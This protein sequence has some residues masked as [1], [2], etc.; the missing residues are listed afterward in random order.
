MKKRDE[1]IAGY[2]CAVSALAYLDGGASVRVTELFR[3]GA[4]KK[5]VLESADAA[6]IKRFK[7]YGLL[8]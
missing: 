1:F 8:S 4:P 5:Q 6:D 3:A 7:E 2:Y